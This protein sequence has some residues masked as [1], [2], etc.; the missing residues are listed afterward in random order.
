ME[1]DVGSLGLARNAGIEL[2]EGEFVWTA[3]GDD[4]VSSNA[5]VELVNTARNHPHPNVVVF[6]EFLPRLALSIM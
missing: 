4:L 2:A 3:D 5:I 6:V 1:I